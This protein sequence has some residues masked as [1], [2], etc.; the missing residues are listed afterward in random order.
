MHSLSF[1]PTEI[2]IRCL[3]FLPYKD[4]V[5]CTGVSKQFRDIIDA[6]ATLEYILELGIA[7][8]EDASG[9]VSLSKC[10]RNYHTTA[11]LLRALREREHAWSTLS[12]TSSWI[13]PVGK[14][15]IV[16]ELCGPAFAGCY[17]RG[18]T[19]PLHGIAFNMIDVFD[20][21]DRTAQGPMVSLTLDK[22][23]YNF[24][25][26][27]GQDLLIVV[28]EV[29]PLAYVQSIEPASRL[30]NSSNS[31]VWKLHIRSLS[32]GLPYNQVY[33]FAYS[34]LQSRATK[35]KYYQPNHNIIHVPV[36]HENWLNEN[37]YP[38]ATDIQILGDVVLFAQRRGPSG[39][40]GI[41][42]ANWKTCEIIYVGP[43]F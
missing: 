10:G 38:G 42:V 28:E 25:I 14:R 19:P 1:L 13:I 18:S 17:L 26:D 9:R 41:A 16:W 11:D 36:A 5:V 4:L 40:G 8:L 35:T 29:P 32:S 43:F 22:P 37:G 24:S 33:P 15:Y 30:T 27:P 6:S 39:S 2:I 20:L 12:C 3:S 31:L 34:E 21:R 23:F 7:G